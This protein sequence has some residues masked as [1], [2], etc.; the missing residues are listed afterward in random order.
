MA[1]RKSVDVVTRNKKAAIRDSS[2]EFKTTVDGI[3]NV[4]TSLDHG[5]DCRMVSV[6][7]VKALSKGKLLAI[8]ELAA[9][10]KIETVGQTPLHLMKKMVYSV[11][12]ILEGAREK[13]RMD[14]KEE[15]EQNTR[16]CHSLNFAAKNS[17][18]MK[19][20]STTTKKNTYLNQSEANEYTEG[21]YSQH[22]GE[23]I[24]EVK[25]AGA[26]AESINHLT[27]LL[28]T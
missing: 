1:D 22:F 19:W 21:S 14:E 12:A 18:K 28:W 20:I 24:K 5:S 15:T 16:I 17:S 13:K 8:K 25:I 23:R 2:G 4:N 7:M 9:P 6:G 10:V 11:L 26:R 3:A 27:E